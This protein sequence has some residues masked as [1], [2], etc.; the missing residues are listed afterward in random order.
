MSSGAASSADV[1]STLHIL[2]EMLA[3]D[4][5]DDDGEAA[6]NGTSAIEF[7]QE[8][9]IAISRVTTAK[10]TIIIYPTSKF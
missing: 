7:S 3:N 1:P 8:E 10:P 6:A 4:S 5:L 9:K 2:Q